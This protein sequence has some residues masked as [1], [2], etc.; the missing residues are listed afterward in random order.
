[1]LIKDPKKVEKIKIKMKKDGVKK[2]HILSDFDRTLTYGTVN[3]KKTPSIISLLRDGNHLSKDYAREANL[4]FEKYHAIEIDQNIPL[5]EKKEAM[6]EWW[7]IHDELLIKS[8][9]SRNDLVDIVSNN[10]FLKLRNG[11]IRFLKTLHR[12]NI[13]LVILSASGCGEAIEM[14]FQK[15]GV[16]YPNIH[17]IINKF[18]WDKDGKA[19]SV[20]KPIIYPMNK[21]EILVKKMP[22]IYREV[23]DRKNVILLGD[24]IDDISMI[25]G[26][27]YDNLLKIGFLNFEISKQKEFYLNSFDLIIGGDGS[28]VN[29]NKIINYLID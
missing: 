18:N 15:M 11:V 16:N 9:L 27:D 22:S 4:L 24:N 13:P 14:L 21:D 17:F 5:R 1:M 25:D 29:I 23:K 6:K 12:H 10:G 3:G 26:F 8:G 28:F 2:L 7:R 20:A 19:I